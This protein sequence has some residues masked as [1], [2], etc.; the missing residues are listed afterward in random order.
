MFSSDPNPTAT[1]HRLNLNQTTT[2]YVNFTPKKTTIKFQ[3]KP[4]SNTQY[5]P[6]RNKQNSIF[7]SFTYDSEPKT[8]LEAYKS[9]Y[10][11]AVSMH[12]ADKRC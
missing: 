11:T 3:F 4:Y 1:K 10:N 6:D 9:E 5:T 7:S 12:K 2:Q 8:N